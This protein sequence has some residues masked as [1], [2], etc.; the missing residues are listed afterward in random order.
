MDAK[1]FDHLTRDFFRT[2][3]RRRVLAGLAAGL[4]TALPLARGD[5]PVA[6]KKKKGKKKQ[7]ACPSGQKACNFGG[8]HSCIPQAHCCLSTD[9][10]PEECGN[11]FC[12][13]DGSCG[14]SF[15]GEKHQGMC[16]IR[17]TC[18]QAF[19]VVG[20]A[21][22]CCSKFSFQ[23]ENGLQRCGGGG[24]GECL[25][26]LDCASGHCRG[27]QCQDGAPPLHCLPAPPP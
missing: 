26:Y 14:C 21:A 17:P 2:A 23:A 6:A 20:S 8:R 18:K 16:G 4:L 24:F 5:E 15:G 12:L 13:P 25:I 9:C 22:E 7:K 3:S 1:H 10:S 11:E 27:F 19:T